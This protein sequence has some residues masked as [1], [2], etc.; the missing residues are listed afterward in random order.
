MGP[1]ATP[2]AIV[3][4]PTDAVAE[5][6]DGCDI[7]VHEVYA[8]Q[9]FDRLPP[10]AQ[11]YHSSFHTSAV[12][13]GRIAARAR[14]KLLVLYHQLFFG[15]TDEEILREVREGFAGRVVSGKDLEVY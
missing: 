11:A 12:A 3:S 8:Q 7:L 4:R 13:L 2:T 14:P 15:S 5:T 10:G 6:C 9:G 1:G